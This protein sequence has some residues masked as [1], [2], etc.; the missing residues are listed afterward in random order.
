MPTHG[1]VENEQKNFDF[2]ATFLKETLADV[3]ACKSA[4]EMKNKIY[5]KFNH[6]QN[7]NLRDLKYDE[8]K[9]MQYQ[10]ITHEIKELDKKSTNNF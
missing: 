7:L 9:L 1:K 2:L 3:D 4:L 10:I 8:K 5:E 6:L